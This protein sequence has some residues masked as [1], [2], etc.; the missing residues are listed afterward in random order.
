MQSEYFEQED[1]VP[2][3]LHHGWSSNRTKG[4]VRNLLLNCEFLQYS[5][6]LAHGNDPQRSDL[7][8][9]LSL[10]TNGLGI[11]SKVWR[12]NKGVE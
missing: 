5:N 4:S 7:Q 11:G 1:K 12:E 9:E 10:H 3:T 8:A 6:W 2:V